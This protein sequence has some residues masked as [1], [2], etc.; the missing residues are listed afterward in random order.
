[1][2][3][4][5][6]FKQRIQ[7]QFGREIKASEGGNTKITNKMF[8]L[9]SVKFLLSLSKKKRKIN[10]RTTLT[11]SLVTNQEKPGNTKENGAHLPTVPK[12]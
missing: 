8:T 3:N 1:M 12:W 11:P 6:S 4:Q 10:N 9:T 2:N 7:I 5:V